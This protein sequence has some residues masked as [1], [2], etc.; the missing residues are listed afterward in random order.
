MFSGR[1]HAGMISYEFL[2]TYGVMIAAGKP[3][4]VQAVAAAR[5]RLDGDGRD[6]PVLGNAQRRPH[7]AI[8][9]AH[10]RACRVWPHPAF[11]SP[12][13][14]GTRRLNLQLELT[15][16]LNSYYRHTLGL[17]RTIFSRNGYQIVNPEFIGKGGMPRDG[18]HFSTAHQLGSCRM[19]ESKRTGVCNA[20]GEVFG[21]PGLYVTDGA[22]IPSSLAVNTSLSPSWPTPSASRRGFSAGTG[23]RTHKS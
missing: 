10:D 22:A 9:Q 19:G 14:A 18:L 8:P 6:G 1:S 11:W 13:K 2:K 7:E 17:L 3:L 21:Y 15:H 4:P 12:F 20:A 16:G 5:L 23:C